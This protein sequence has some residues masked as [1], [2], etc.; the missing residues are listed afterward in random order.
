M[1]RS[2]MVTAVFVPAAVPV[3]GECDDSAEVGGCLGCRKDGVDLL[4]LAISFTG[5]GS[6]PSDLDFTK[7]LV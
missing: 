4:M 6:N 3:C 5:A 7:W 1:N 2:G